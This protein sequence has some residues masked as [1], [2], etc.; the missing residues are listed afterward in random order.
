[1]AAVAVDLEILVVTQVITLHL[2]AGEDLAVEDMVAE[3]IHAQ[4]MDHHN[5]L[6]HKLE[7]NGMHRL[8]MLQWVAVAVA[9]ALIRLI[10]GG[11]V[12]LV[13]LES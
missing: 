2:L 6:V 4:D 7:M 10:Q 12:N 5:D 13:D 8:D 3:H 11:R 1:M 9:Q